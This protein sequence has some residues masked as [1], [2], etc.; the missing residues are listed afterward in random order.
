MRDMQILPRLSDSMSFLY[1]EQVVVHRN[2]NTIEAIDDEGRIPIPV[3]SLSALMLGPGCSISHAAINILAKNG[4]TVAWVGEDGT[5]FYACGMGETYKAYNLMRQAEM[6]CDT[7]KRKQV[8]IRMYQMRFEEPLDSAMSLPQIRGYE[9]VRVRQIYAYW[10]EKCNVPWR[11]RAYNFQDWGGDPINRALSSANA[12][13]NAICHAVIV[14]AGFSPALGFIHQGR[15]MSFVYDIAD[16][17]K[18]EIT[19]P[20]A[21]EVVGEGS[22]YVE[23]RVRQAMREKVRESKLMSRILPDIY[24]FLNVSEDVE[25]REEFIDPHQTHPIPLW[26]ALFEERGGER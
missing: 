13:L 3:A 1:L 8:V 11:G 14:S 21:F 10:S 20:C 5:R 12:V 22:V 9:G 25:E 16:V 15:Q 17:Y 6:V 26:E 4:C 2:Q 23:K 24:Q 18:T 19:I 7:D